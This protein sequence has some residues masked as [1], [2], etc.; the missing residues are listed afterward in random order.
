[1]RKGN[2]RFSCRKI[3][4]NKKRLRIGSQTHRSNGYNTFFIW[5]L[6]FLNCSHNRKLKNLFFYRFFL[7]N[8]LLHRYNW[9][10]NIKILTIPR[11]YTILL[12]NALNSKFNFFF[13]F[14]F[15]GLSAE[16]YYVRDG[17][18]NEYALHFIVPVPANVRDIAFTWQSLAGRPVSH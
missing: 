15:S 12:F 1:M 10:S 9:N 18:V 17:Q 5:K 7:L 16:L 2:M 6:D 13:P 8:S 3:E 4:K 14:S 11:L